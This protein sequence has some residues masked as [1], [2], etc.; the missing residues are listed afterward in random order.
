MSQQTCLE[1]QQRVPPIQRTALVVTFDD[2]QSRPMEAGINFLQHAKAWIN[3]LQHAKAWINYV[4][5]FFFPSLLAVLV[6]HRNG[7]RRGRLE[8]KGRSDVYEQVSRQ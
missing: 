8:A 1:L 5:A 7:A 4:Q 2:V 6:L 3:F